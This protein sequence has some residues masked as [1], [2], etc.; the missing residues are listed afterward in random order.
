M[1][2]YLG[3]FAIVLAAV[4]AAVLT[5]LFENTPTN[6]VGAMWYGFPV[7]WLYQLVISPEYYPWRVDGINLTLDV[8]FW[9]LI[10][11]GILYL[12]VRIRGRSRIDGPA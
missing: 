9:A 4:L 10:F 1:D 3:A 5:G 12:A 11:T 7:A 2:R 6:L 8:L